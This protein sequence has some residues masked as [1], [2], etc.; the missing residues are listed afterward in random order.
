M[1]CF[2]DYLKMFDASWFKVLT[3]FGVW[4][5]VWFPV[6]FI[7]SRSIGFQADE[8][9]TPKQKIVLLASLYLLSPIVLSWKIN[10]EN[11][12]FRDL[13]LYLQIDFSL[14]ILF[15]LTIGLLSL[16]IIF[17][18]ES[19]FNLV[20]WH[21]EQI[22]ELFSLVLPIFALSLFVSLVEELVFRGYVFS[23][24]ANDYPYWIAAIISSFIFA[25]LHLIWE[26]QET[27]P[28]IPG[29]WLMGTILVAARIVDNGG[30]GL[31]IGLHASWIWGLTCIDSAQLITYRKENSW[32]TGLN[33]QPLAGIAGISCLVMTGFVLWLTTVSNL[34]IQLG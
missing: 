9:L 1:Y 12:S 29:L 5:F 13:G 15:G 24:L 7:I 6:A 28:Q 32:L 19:I 26:R 23:T 16:S 22:K 8:P 27:L 20:D 17:A 34:S 14:S 11:L 31:A 25:L 33:Q 4:S 18:I 21:K 3:F 2:L 30:L 10:L